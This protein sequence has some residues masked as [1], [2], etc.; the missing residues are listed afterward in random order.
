M[1]RKFTGGFLLLNSLLAAGTISLP[2]TGADRDDGSLVRTHDGPVQGFVENGVHEFLGV[3]YAAPPVG[4]LRW[5]PPQP[6]APWK[7]PLNATAYGN[8]CP[9]NFELGV[10]A[11][12]PSTTEDCL[13]LNVF[14]TNLGR[15][16]DRDRRGKDPV[17]LWI[18]GGGWYDGESN[19]YD[20]SQLALGGPSGP[21]VVVTINYR[22]GLLGF[23]AHPALEAEGH[24]FADYGLMDQQAALRWVQ[25]NIAAFGGDPANVTVGGQSAGAVSAAANVASPTAAGLFHRAIIESGPSIAFAPLELAETRGANFATKAGC[26]TDTSAA[27]AACLRALSV[28]DILGLQMPYLTGLIMDGTILPIQADQAW[29]TGQFNRVPIINGT[30]EDE[31][32][33]GAT[34]NEFFSGQPMT[35]AGYTNL[36]TGIYSGN[37]N[38]FNGPSGIAG[39]P[40]NYPAGTAAKV[41]A[42]YPLA[43]YASPSLAEIAVLTDTE[44]CRARHLN[45]LLSQWV[46][47][48]AYEF[49]DRNAPWYFPP[50]SFPH[51]AAHTID[52]QFFFPLWH[53]GPMGTPHPLTIQERK[54]SDEMV[55]AATSFM[56]TG[57]PN[58]EGNHPWPRY[59][60][61]S[62]IYFSENVPRLST[63]KESDFSSAHQCAF[64]DS[65]LV[66]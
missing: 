13:Y 22:L 24:P 16:A 51:G 42:Q 52:L 46:P 50:L 12:P 49:R 11:G 7:K 10:Y 8:T 55:A 1:R 25:Q 43:A 31:G 21:T 34:L 66:Y 53:G 41:L 30:V 18:H 9:Q 2:A 28:E 26:G 4:P 59:D 40:P 29:T 63:L 36:V 58:F 14:T 15:D 20:A 3:P 27:A 23:L 38:I 48:Y 44:S 33:F 6:P 56:S 47:L 39:V 65:I 19:D 62:P 61:D 45:H 17:L 64:W 57:D 35:A 60:A 5:M 37:T 54:L 32:G